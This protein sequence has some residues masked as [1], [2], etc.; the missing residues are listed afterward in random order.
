MNKAAL[1]GCLHL[2]RRE[3]E[4]REA[5]SEASCRAQIQ[6]ALAKPVALSAMPRLF[7]CNYG[8]QPGF[9]QPVL[10]STSNIKRDS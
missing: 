4:V 5:D 7:Q 10:G 9:T 6:Q 1:T 2:G 8:L 3:S